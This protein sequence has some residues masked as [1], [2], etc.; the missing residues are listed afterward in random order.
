MT[1]VLR[2]YRLTL[3]SLAAI[4]VLPGTGAYA[5][6]PA[7][8]TAHA[9]ALA[10]A[11]FH[12]CVRNG[13]HAD[14]AK[15]MRD[16]DPDAKNMRA[17]WKKDIPD[18]EGTPQS[19]ELQVGGYRAQLVYYD[20]TCKLSAKVA[21]AAKLLL[22][23][24]TEAGKVPTLAQRPFPTP[25]PDV[26]VLHR[27]MDGITPGNANRV[28]ELIVWVEEAGDGT[29]YVWMERADPMPDDAPTSQNDVPPSMI[30]EP[31]PPPPIIRPSKERP[32]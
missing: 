4:F 15:A 24:D 20:G 19:L 12:I 27:R 23:F 29:A 13:A 22:A 26:Q 5:Q 10:D 9:Q 31:P 14:I 7:A 1:H 28:V 8:D 16:V 30:I 17:A 18:P 6:A 2:R 3:L 25:V 32:E 21:T 11:F